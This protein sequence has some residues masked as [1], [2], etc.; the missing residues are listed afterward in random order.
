MQSHAC[1]EQL[2]CSPRSGW[3]TR[4]SPI[5]W[6]SASPLRVTRGLGQQHWLQMEGRW[7]CPDDRRSRSCKGLCVGEETPDKHWCVLASLPRQ[8]RTRVDKVSEK[9]APA[10][11][12]GKNSELRRVLTSKASALLNPHLFRG[13]ESSPAPTHTSFP[14]TASARG[15]GPRRAPAHASPRR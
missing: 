10:L 2:L 6:G 4:C 15:A 5:S 12:G 3:G 8:S 7:E 11:H 14:D 13:E 9:L 1:T